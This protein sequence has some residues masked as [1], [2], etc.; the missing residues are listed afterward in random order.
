MGWELGLLA[1]TTLAA[2]MLDR[3][4]SLRLEAAKAAGRRPNPTLSQA[5]KS[6]RIELSCQGRTGRSARRPLKTSSSNASTRH[7]SQSLRARRPGAGHDGRFVGLPGALAGRRAARR[8][9]L[10]HAAVRSR[11][12]GYTPRHSHPYEHEV[13]VLEGEGVVLEGDTSI[14]CAAGDVVLVVPDEVHQFRNTGSTP[15]KFLCLVPNSSAEPAGD[16]GGRVQPAGRIARPT[17]ANPLPRRLRASQ[18]DVTAAAEI[19]KLRDEIRR[20]RSASTT[21]RPSPRSPT[22]STTG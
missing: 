9:E 18:H 4:R 3:V 6:G 7:E 11:P 20:P 13:F 1:V 17:L 21:S 15:L 8:A 19:E 22:A 5:G 16:R 10:C 2:M 14:R 12:G